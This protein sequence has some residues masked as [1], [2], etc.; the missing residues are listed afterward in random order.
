MLSSVTDLLIN[1]IMIVVSGG[2][3]D[4]YSQAA[5]NALAEKT[6]VVVSTHHSQVV[7]QDKRLQ[8]YVSAQQFMIFRS[9]C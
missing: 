8:G 3:D 1:S 7:E 6:Q 4:A 9:G 5:L 2:F